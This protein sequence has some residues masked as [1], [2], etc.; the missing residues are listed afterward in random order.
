MNKM[1]GCNPANFNSGSF[2]NTGSA[3]WEKQVDWQ[4]DYEW[5]T[6]NGCA[7]EPK[8]P[9]KR[10]CYRNNDDSCFNISGRNW[11]NFSYND[12]NNCRNDRGY[13][14]MGGR[15]NRNM[16]MHGFGR[17]N[18][19]FNNF[20]YIFPNNQPMQGAYNPRFVDARRFCNPTV[21]QYYFMNPAMQQQQQQQQAFGRPT[22]N[23]FMM[24]PAMQ[25]QQQQQQV[26]G[27]PLNLTLN[28]PANAAPQ[29]NHR[30]VVFA[31]E[32]VMC[33]DGK[34]EVEMPSDEPE[35]PQTEK[36]HG[37]HR[38]HGRIDHTPTPTPTTP[39]KPEPEKLTE[40][41]IKIE[42]TAKPEVKP[43]PVKPEPVKPEPEKCEVCET[44]VT[45]EPDKIITKTPDIKETYRSKTGDCLNG[46]ASKFYDVKTNEEIAELYKKANAEGA[47]EADKKLYKDEVAKRD[48]VT[49]LLGS[50]NPKALIDGD[51]NRI[52]ADVDIKIPD[53]ELYKGDNKKTARCDGKTTYPADPA[54]KPPTTIEVI[55]GKETTETICKESTCEKPADKVTTK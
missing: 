30:K 53:H 16:P 32:I 55:P 3:S 51:K 8:C 28:L 36:P 29:Q 40:E 35:K 23:F 41:W 18:M 44:K 10:D 7:P 43:D 25:Q 34:V 54:G 27:K 15:D 42:N 20:N 12:D 33:G 48:K 37:H 24:N 38:P 11:S 52:Y 47:T 49:E 31:P 13:F 4:V 1:S 39:S 6:D 19:S 45:R 5:S 50:M 46:I 21:N 9:P 14:G 26:Q 22:Y 17:P 2:C